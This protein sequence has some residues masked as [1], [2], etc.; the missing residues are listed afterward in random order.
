MKKFL[1]LIIALIICFLA[2]GCVNIND[3][4][5][6]LITDVFGNENRLNSTS[7]IVSCY[8][9]FTECYMLSG[10]SL[11]GVTSD[12]INEHNL[13]LDKSVE[14][15]GSVK[16]INLEKIV[17]LLPN[18]VILSADLTAH[19]QLEPQ[20]KTLKIPYGYFRVDTFNDYKNLMKVF[21]EINCREDLYI[22]NVLDIE[23]S[24]AKIK[25][26]TIKTNKTALLMRAYS[27]GIKAKKSDNIAGT[28]IKELGLNNIAETTPSLLEN[29]SLEHIVWTNP[30]YIFL[31]TMGD[32]EK[33]LEYVK[34]NLENNLAWSNL[35]AVKNKKFIVLPKELFHY[36]PNNRWDKSYEFIKDAIEK[37]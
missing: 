28:I 16:S 2:V 29:M 30:D 33:A 13:I 37:N 14:I 36:K 6:V 25:N 27:T 17:E 7:K 26:S 23:N 20:L 15:V 3:K 11:V 4:D 22:K 31:L 18:Y 9:S 35:K 5:G 19:L 10:G 21:C 8:G 1:S 32:E 24:I 12:A 34:N